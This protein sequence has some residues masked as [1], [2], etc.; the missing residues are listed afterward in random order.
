MHARLL[1]IFQRKNWQSFL[2]DKRIRNYKTALGNRDVCDTQALGMTAWI[3]HHDRHNRSVIRDI[4][5]FDELLAT[6][7]MGHLAEDL[8]RAGTPLQN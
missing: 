2:A 1:G 7:L 8:N 6:Y 4:P 5:E 3:L